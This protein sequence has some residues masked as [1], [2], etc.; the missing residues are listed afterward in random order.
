MEFVLVFAKILVHAQLDQLLIAFELLFVEAIQNLFFL[1]F[2]KCEHNI[3]D[4]LGFLSD[5]VRIPHVAEIV[6]ILDCQIGGFLDCLDVEFCED[7][8]DVIL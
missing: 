2:L 8:G 4:N 6:L 3:A 7:F 1:F 5:S